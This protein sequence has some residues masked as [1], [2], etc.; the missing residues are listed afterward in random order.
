MIMILKD[1]PKDFNYITAHIL[2]FAHLN[3]LICHYICNGTLD[4]C[5]HSQGPRSL[6]IMD[7][8]ICLSAPYRLLNGGDMYTCSLIINC[9][10]G[11]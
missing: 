8:S 2:E 11:L 9:Y 5:L 3:E 7:C 10:M 6:T 1:D 4:K